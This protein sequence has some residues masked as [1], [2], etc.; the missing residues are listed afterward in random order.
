[1]PAE[2]APAPAPGT[3]RLG[4]RAPV[5]ITVDAAANTIR[6]RLSG[7]AT[8]D[9]STAIRAAG[10]IDIGEQGRLLGVEVETPPDAAWTVPPASSALV[11]GGGDGTFYIAL[12]RD[13]GRHAR[14]VPV[15]VSLRLTPARLLAEV[16]VPRRGA[17]YEITYPS[18]NR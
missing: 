7:D 16:I 14:S 11:Q 18:G 17:G 1:M 4:E 10:T 2:P 3:V 5:K 15:E 8:A 12:D 13:T 9:A 6:F